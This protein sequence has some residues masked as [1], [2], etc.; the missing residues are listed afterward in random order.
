[1]NLVSVSE[2]VMLTQSGI[3]VIAGLDWREHIKWR[4]NRI[5]DTQ[6]SIQ[7]FWMGSGR[8]GHGFPPSGIL[9]SPSSDIGKLVKQ[10]DDDESSGSVKRL[11][12]V[13]DPQGAGIW[14][15]LNRS[16]GWKTLLENTHSYDCIILIGTDIGLPR[17]GL[18]LEHTDWFQ[19]RSSSGPRSVDELTSGS[20]SLGSWLDGVGRDVFDDIR[21]YRRILSVMANHRRDVVI[22][23]SNENDDF[24]ERVLWWNAANE[25]VQNDYDRRRVANPVDVDD[26]GVAMIKSRVVRKLRLI[27]GL[28]E[29]LCE[30]LDDSDDDDES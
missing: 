27:V 17:A 4:T 8:L 16:V 14:D 26:G 2:N 3:W 11:I 23:L 22:W 12:V 28:L 7:A 25:H 15:G 24:T 30:E 13:E 20:T 10:W 9:T 21:V 29:E 6:P 19:L 1:M 18:L 5:L